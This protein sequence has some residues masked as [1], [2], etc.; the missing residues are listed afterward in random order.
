MDIDMDDEVTLHD[1]ILTL[2]DIGETNQGTTLRLLSSY[3]SDAPI[4]E[5]RNIYNSLRTTGKWPNK[6]VIGV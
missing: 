4:E 6:Q 5:L 1:K 2:T 3:L